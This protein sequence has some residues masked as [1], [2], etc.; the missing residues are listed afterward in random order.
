MSSKLDLTNVPE[1]FMPKQGVRERWERWLDPRMGP[2]EQGWW[3]GWCPLHDDDGRT[4]RRNH[5]AQFHFHR[6][7]LRC[8]REN[9]ECHEMK[10]D[11]RKKAITLVNVQ[12]ALLVRDAQRA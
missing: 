3:W 11:R 6:G 7:S 5:S 8:L 2:D 9:T 4:R 1:I 10:G 12:R